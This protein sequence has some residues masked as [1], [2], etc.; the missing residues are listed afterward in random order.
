MRDN[1]KCDEIDDCTSVCDSSCVFY[2]D[3]IFCE[4]MVNVLGYD[5]I[6][7]NHLTNEFCKNCVYK[8]KPIDFFC[9]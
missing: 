2:G 3:C 9:E 7:I 4:H 8:D 5:D 1:F 6:R